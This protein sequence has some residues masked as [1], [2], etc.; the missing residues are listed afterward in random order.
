MM[1]FC[2]DLN[3]HWPRWF[4]LEIWCFAPWTFLGH[5]PRSAETPYSVVLENT[6]LM[7]AWKHFELVVLD[8]LAISSSCKVWSQRRRAGSP[9]PYLTMSFLRQSFFCCLG[10]SVSR[11]VHFAGPL[12]RARSESSQ[13]NLSEIGYEWIDEMT[14]PPSIFDTW[15]FFALDFLL[16]IPRSSFNTWDPWAWLTLDCGA[17]ESKCSN[18]FTVAALY[19]VTSK[20]TLYIKVT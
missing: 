11:R 3:M 17:G 2:L 13:L 18:V 19:K 16:E 9:W 14:V 5:K 10:L 15:L 8:C 20:V 1:Y 12:W 7:W 4:C 6:R